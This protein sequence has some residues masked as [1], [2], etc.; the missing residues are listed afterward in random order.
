MKYKNWFIHSIG[1]DEMLY[2][3]QY[4][5]IQDN[6]MRGLLYFMQDFRLLIMCSREKN[7]E[8]QEQRHEALY[9]CF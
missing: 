7:A 4:F 6:L 2:L 1:L 8:K 3:I 5:S 9:S